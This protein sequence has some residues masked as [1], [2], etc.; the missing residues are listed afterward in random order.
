MQCQATSPIQMF[1]YK[2]DV[3]DMCSCACS[4]TKRRVFS[5]ILTYEDTPMRNFKHMTPHL[6]HNFP[7]VHSKQPATSQPFNLQ[8]LLKGQ[9]ARLKSGRMDRH[10]YYYPDTMG[11]DFSD[12]RRCRFFFDRSIAKI[13]D[14]DPPK[15]NT[16]DQVHNDRC[17]RL[18]FL[19]QL[20]QMKV[21]KGKQVIG[22]S[23]C[24]E[25]VLL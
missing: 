13:S 15:T 20:K 18:G 7:Q 5:H 21:I 17:F 16:A 12:F 24:F 19:L 10:Q 9:Y 23:V 2:C 8:T 1:P 4:Q 6:S 11:A 22:L 25:H 3:Y 14:A